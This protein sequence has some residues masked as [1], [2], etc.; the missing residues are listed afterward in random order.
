MAK[1]IRSKSKRKFRAI[2]R[3]AVFKPVEDVRLARVV[4]RLHK[5]SAV[6]SVPEPP[7]AEK[8]YS[9]SFKEA[10]IDEPA[11]QAREAAEA[12]KMEAEPQETTPA[13][14]D[15][16]S[17]GMEVDGEGAEK[18]GAGRCPKDVQGRAKKRAPKP[19]QTG[20]TGG[21]FV[22]RKTKSGKIIKSFK[23]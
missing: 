8:L 23:W 9:F 20:F 21:G 13:F 14:V 6:V 18:A 10:L 5:D 15:E 12:A 4:H 2:K 16:D 11:R 1:S 22:V 19:I 17:A 3:E 7:P